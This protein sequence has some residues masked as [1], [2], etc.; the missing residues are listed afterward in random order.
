[1][2][3][4]SKQITFKLEHSKFKNVR[5]DLSVHQFSKDI[6][7]QVVEKDYEPQHQILDLLPKQ[8][9]RQYAIDNIEDVVDADEVQK[10]IAKYE[11]ENKETEDVKKVDNIEKKTE[12]FVP[13]EKEEKSKPNW[14]LKIFLIAGVFALGFFLW[15]KYGNQAKSLLNVTNTKSE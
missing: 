12:H 5:T 15:K 11:S 13:S 6:V 1:M 8:A 10:I 9:V 7:R 4:M 2:D 3:N 14:V